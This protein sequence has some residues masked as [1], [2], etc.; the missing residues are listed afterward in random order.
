MESVRI[1]SC[2]DTNWMYFAPW[3]DLNDMVRNCIQRSVPARPLGWDVEPS[4]LG[5]ILQ[6]DMIPK[7]VTDLAL[8]SIDDTKPNLWPNR[9]N[10]EASKQVLGDLNNEAFVAALEE[11]TTTGVLR[12]HI[13]RLNSS[14]SC[15]RIPRDQFPSLCPGE[16]PFTRSF[17]HGKNLTR[18]CVPGNFGVSPWTISRNRQD[19]TEEIFLDI[20]EECIIR[21]EPGYPRSGNLTSD[22]TLHCTAN[23]TRGY[24]ELGNYRNN[25]SWSP[26]FESW[27]SSDFIETESNDYMSDHNSTYPTDLYVLHL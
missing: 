6:E 11:G 22:Y 4:E 26:L 19:I 24:F 10:P 1:P 18:I 13:I 5:E 3:K 23:T 21:S 12:E 16:Y 2:Q 14:V 8:V 7:L 9:S 17:P 20:L 27:P 25:N 15:N